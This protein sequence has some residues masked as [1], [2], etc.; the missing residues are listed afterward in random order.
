MVIKGDRRRA[1]RRR[2]AYGLAVWMLLACLPQLA[3]SSQGGEGT[4]P[5]SDSQHASL[6]KLARY[7]DPTPP[8]NEANP[9]V[10]PT[11]VAS[12]PVARP[13]PWPSNGIDA[14]RAAV[15]VD[16]PSVEALPVPTTGQV[17]A[18]TAPQS[19]AQ[20]IAIPPQ[21]AESTLMPTAPKQ[22]VL[23]LGQPVLKDVVVKEDAGLISLMVRDAPLRQVVAL[24]A[25]TQNLNIVFASPAD[26]PVTASFD[27]VPWQQVIESLLSISG[28][29][30]T[31]SDGI[32]YI[33]SIEAADLVSPRA[34]GQ[35]I[36]VFELDYASAVDVDQTVKGILSPVGK[37]WVLESST[38]DNR[39]TREA[40]AVVDFPA[41]LTRISEYVCQVDQP[42]RQ[43]LI[44]ANIL[45][46]KLNDDCRS[47]IN[48]AALA[49]WSGNKEI[50]FGFLSAGIANPQNGFDTAAANATTFLTVEGPA[51]L[52]LVQALKAT[53]DTKTLASPKVLAVSGQKSKIQIGDRLGYTVLNTNVNQSTQQQVQFLEVGVILDV[54][55]RITRDGRVL[56]NV[57]PNVSTGEVTNDIPSEH[58][59]NVES[60]VLL[61]DGQGMV[62]G[63]LIQEADNIT[64]RKIP[65]LGDLPYVG[66]LFQ[67]R[68]VVKERKEIIVTLVPHI[69]PYSPAVAEREQFDYMRANERLTQGAIYRNP[70]PYEPR[71]YDTFLNP[72]HPV[73]NL[74]A[75]HHA[76]V[77]A[78]IQAMPD[79]MI[80][81]PPVEECPY[82]EGEYEVLPEPAAGPDIEFPVEQTTY[83]HSPSTAV[84]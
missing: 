23:P 16:A 18:A 39:R 45:E 34:G 40:V 77:E 27:R 14:L 53:T 76:S 75:M 79:G 1:E 29:V 28:H 74:H 26:V 50:G 68:Q 80:M 57:K 70:R 48:F 63:G 13:W 8:A 37:S 71:M 32:V 69:L 11:E 31:M 38:D 5:Q 59:T 84:R 12:P 20:G 35:A 25:E 61:N 44:E 65:W 15:G 6:E 3:A 4:T 42:P 58:T 19:G 46:V 41:N 30:W 36:E 43:V 33:T 56:M 10:A 49:S 24:V 73:A 7:E 21:N 55:P 47:G 83:N 17:G 78:P 9:P 52:G 67:Q 64:S 82:P 51:L 60:S 72:R 22:H 81:L 62:I 66:I 2:W 54:I